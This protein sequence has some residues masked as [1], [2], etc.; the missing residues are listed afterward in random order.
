MAAFRG[1]HWTVF[2]HGLIFR[3]HAAV[4]SMMDLQYSLYSPLSAGFF[5]L[6]LSVF[7]LKIFTPTCHFKRL[8]SASAR[9]GESDNY[10]NIHLLCS[11]FIQTFPIST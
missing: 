3:Y 5:S 7:T 8:L 9:K 1:Q 11:S 10:D 4:I 6:A 2:M